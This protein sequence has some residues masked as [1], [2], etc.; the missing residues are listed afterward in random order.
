MTIL[1]K[2]DAEWLLENVKYFPSDKM[3]MEVTLV[4]TAVINNQCGTKH[5]MVR[6]ALHSN[7]EWPV[8][9]KSLNPD[10]MEPIEKYSNHADFARVYGINLED[11]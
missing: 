10:K 4:S 3:S 8:T 5:I 11:L 6:V 7:P 2:R 9:V 1:Y